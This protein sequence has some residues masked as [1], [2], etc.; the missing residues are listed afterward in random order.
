MSLQEKLDQIRASMAARIPADL[1][2]VMHRAV[3]DLRAS[4]IADR[5][6][7]VGETAPDFDLADTTG[8]PV[9][10]AGLLARGPLVVTFYRG[11]W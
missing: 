8:Q 11:F 10:S 1:Q 7:K 2:E 6:L 4:G 3:E 5:L 9:R